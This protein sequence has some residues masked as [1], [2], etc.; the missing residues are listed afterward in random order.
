MIPDRLLE[1]DPHI[2]GAASNYKAM[3]FK[4]VNLLVCAANGPVDALV[5]PP[6]EHA[7][8]AE[9]YRRALL[10]K[11]PNTAD[12]TSCFSRT[13]AV[14]AATKA[15]LEEMVASLTYEPTGG[16]KDYRRL[17]IIDDIFH[18]GITVSAIITHLQQR[19]LRESCDV[20]V[21]CPLW[22]EGL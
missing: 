19:G 3:R 20:N 6:S 22:L 21:M 15:T 8:Q 4:Y 13:G 14:R 1:K 17:I 11:F 5:S 12:L 9:P 18:R 2:T 16:E 10:K 7:W